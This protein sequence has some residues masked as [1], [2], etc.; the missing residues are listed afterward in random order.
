VD[1]EAAHHLSADSADPDQLID[2]AEGMSLSVGN[3][4]GGLRRTD[5]GQ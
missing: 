3:D 5:A 2:G 1:A 4:L